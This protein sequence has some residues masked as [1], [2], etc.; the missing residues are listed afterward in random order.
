MSIQS[1]EVRYLARLVS[2]SIEAIYLHRNLLHDSDKIN[3]FKASRKLQKISELPQQIYLAETGT[4]VN[5][6]PV[7]SSESLL[8]EV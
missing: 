5:S 2:T 1:R 6:Q 4:L 7:I 8:Q 3:L